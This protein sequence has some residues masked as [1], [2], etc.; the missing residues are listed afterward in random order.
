MV[1]NMLIKLSKL[2]LGFLCVIIA[3]G[4]LMLIV[5]DYSTPIVKVVSVS[6][7]G[8]ITKSFNLNGNVISKN[9]IEVKAPQRLK[10]NKVNV[11]NSQ[12][13]DANNPIIIFDTEGLNIEDTNDMKIKD[14]GIYKINRDIYVE[15][16]NDKDVIE[17]GEVVIKYYLHDEENLEIVTKVD[18]YD[19]KALTHKNT[20]IYY[21]KN[22]YSE[23][24]KTKLVDIKK[25][26]DYNEVVFTLSKDSNEKVKINNNVNIIVEIKEEYNAFIVPITALIPIGDI[27]DYTSCYVYAVVEEDTMFGK[28]NRVILRDAYI[29]SVGASKAA[30]YIDNEDNKITDFKNFKII[31]YATA[32]I[33]DGTRV[34]IK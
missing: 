30:I 8:A 2:F 18:D 4:F 28:Q 17:Q 23:R 5:R 16:I 10:V 33:E 21:Y 3:L 22:Y 1:K 24:A 14:D 29:Y 12:I 19:L 6:N 27:K 34:R 7:G 13:V 32:E 11:E 26:P 20:R 25:F 15:Y 9:V 31:N